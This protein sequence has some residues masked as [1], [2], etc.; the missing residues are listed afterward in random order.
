MRSRSSLA[1]R[2]VILLLAGIAWASLNS[3]CV[4]RKIDEPVFLV[5]GLNGHA[6]LSCNQEFEAVPSSVTNPAGEIKW[7]ASVGYSRMTY[8]KGDWS[9][10]S[11]GSGAADLG[12]PVPV[13]PKDL[14]R[15]Q[16]LSGDSWSTYSEAKNLAFFYF[17]GRPPPS[18]SNSCVAVAATTP[19]NLET[20]VWDYPA[21]CLSTSR[22]DQCAIL[23][24]DDTNTF[25]SA[26]AFS[27][28][29][30]NIRIQ[31][32]DDCPGAPGFSNGCP[33]TALV[34]IPGVNQLQF[35]IAKNPC[36][37]NLV[38]VYRKGKDI[39]LRFYDENLSQINDFKVSGDQSFAVGQSNS[40]CSNGTIRRC[41]LGTEDCCNLTTSN[42]KDNAPGQCLRDNARPS[43][44]TYSRMVGGAQSCGAV[45]AY[46]SMVKGNDGNLWSKSRLDV[47]DITSEASP[48][49]EAHWNSTSDEFTWN[50]YLS[51]AVVTDKG[52]HALHPKIA[53]FWLTDIRGPCNVIAEG[54]TSTNL[55][56]TIQAT[57]IIGGPFPGVYTNSFGIGD[58][59]SGIKGGD[60]DGS[61]YITWGE[62]VITSAASCVA[63]MEDTWNLSTKITRIQW[64]RTG[65]TG[66]NEIVS[67]APVEIEVS[68]E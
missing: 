55:G 22:G 26:C 35:S 30:P 46:D 68:G 10:W 33:R 39:R 60:Q 27:N 18:L 15:L 1:L 38:L 43:I 57:G 59:F 16:T 58:Y 44:D 24:I 64:G 54:A 48:S 6:S 17:I 12:F 25:Y 11:G 20:G 53:W 37:G 19:E 63:C 45:L 40:G 66:K 50:Q 9:K 52:K 61:L 62:P 3:G 32:F 41:G 67:P 5:G 21:T 42:C 65:Q 34:D 7:F 14:F 23:Q 47:V 31:A 13:N 56:A 2:L 28:N 36:T 4:S 29:G 49:V 51:Y 8:A